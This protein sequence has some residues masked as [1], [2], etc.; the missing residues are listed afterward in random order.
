MVAGVNIFGAERGDCKI[1]LFMLHANCIL[2][3]TRFF[4]I[5]IEI[6]SIKTVFFMQLFM[7]IKL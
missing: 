3:S 1:C 5:K 6:E 4:F 7:N 2:W